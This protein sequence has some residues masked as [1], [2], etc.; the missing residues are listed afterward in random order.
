MFIGKLLHQ[1]YL[2]TISQGVHL[3]RETVISSLRLVRDSKTNNQFISLAGNLLSQVQSD[4]ISVSK[5]RFVFF[6]YVLC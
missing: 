4:K 2:S 5:L 1:S 6:L 3:L